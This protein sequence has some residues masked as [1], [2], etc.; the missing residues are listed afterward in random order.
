MADLRDPR[1][2]GPPVFLSYATADRPLAEAAC[3]ALEA[4]GL[5]CWIAPR[6]ITP[7]AD[8]GQAIVEAIGRSRALVLVLSHAANASRQV[9]REVERAVHFGVPIVPFR[10]EAVE[11]TS[12]LSYFI[13]TA[14]WLDALPPPAASHLPRLVAAVRRLLGQ[15]DQ[16]DRSAAVRPSLGQPEQRARG[17]AGTG[18]P[19]ESANAPVA[20]A[21]IRRPARAAA[22][23]VLPFGNRSAD[24]RN[25]WLSDGITED[26]VNAFT[27]LPGLRVASRSSAFAFKA[28]QRNVREI[29]R[30]LN[31]AAVLDGSVQR[32]GDQLRVTAQLIDVADGARLWSETYDRRLADVFAVQ[33][34]LVRAVADRLELGLAGEQSLVVPLTTS[35]EA[36]ELYL[37]GRF[38]CNA[39]N[40]DGLRQAPACFEQAIRADA[41]FALA[42][43]GLAG[44][45]HVLAVEGVLPPR[46]AYAK[47][48]PAAER[49]LELDG[50]LADAHLSAA[51]VALCWD[52]DFAR[53]EQGFRRAIEL[54]PA[55]AQAHHWL[56]WCLAIL[57]RKEE[58]A[59][60]ARR[61]IEL[62]PLSPMLHARAGHLLTYA[63]RPEEG[64]ANSLRALEL[65]PNLAAAAEALA[66]AYLQQHR[67]EEAKAVL[68]R[69]TALP[70]SAAAYYLP[71]VHAV[72]LERDEAM[73]LLRALDL[74]APGGAARLG[75]RGLF[76]ACTYAALGEKDE[77]FH[78]L[79][80]AYADRSP[81]ILLLTV[82]R[83]FDP[84]HS[85]PRFADLV[86]RIG[87]A[88]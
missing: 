28:T 2:T 48:R 72:L 51:Y 14:H 81:A 58:A 55:H 84:L 7:G 80:R 4:N 73:R 62:E 82:E 86:R 10:I 19:A 27:K 71:Y 57:R 11:P 87:L 45:C 59:A 65:D 53:A 74:D 13:S 64:A 15:P 35:L 47:A 70:L 69:A 9:P 23:A 3:A 88:S 49:A 60:A 24:P 67:Y 20:D 83:A 79:E 31:V 39:R 26:L 34:E 63:G 42:Y 54:S 66:A 32:T 30:K 75:H 8:W 52:W 40:P 76:V 33:D 56:G 38:H 85:D 50:R 22:L 46:E 12:G 18:V 6:D 16:A 68:R 43:C 44:S 1:E 36:Y 5:R 78:W 25:E 41:D 17:A 29:G 21:G 77:A 61:A 37:R